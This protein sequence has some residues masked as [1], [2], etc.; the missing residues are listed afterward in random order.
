MLALYGFLSIVLSWFFKMPISIVWSTPGGAL[1][2][3]SGALNYGFPAAVGAFLVAA[4]LLVLTG[5]WPWLGKVAAS[6]PKPI[7]SAMLAG[8]IFNFCIAPIQAVTEFPAIVI[9]A[10]VVWILLMRF[11]KIWAAP[12]AMTI[13][14]L[15][16]S[17]SQGVQLDWA[18]W[19]PKFE[20]VT[21][22]FSWAAVISIGIPLYLVTMASQNIPGVAIMKSLGFEVPFAASMVSTGLGSLVSGLF[23]G[24][25][26]N[27]AAITAAL[28]ADEHAH[29]DR[30]KRWLAS[31]LGG[32]GYIAMA[33]VAGLVV[34]LALKMPHS[35]ILTAAG[36]ALIVTI[37]NAL[38][39]ATEDESLRVPAIVTFLTTTSG[40]VI[41]GIG[42][43]F[44]ALIVGV[45]F[46]VVTRRIPKA[47]SRL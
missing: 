2:V 1:L 31:V 46:W 14:L 47:A 22:E 29:P 38:K 28:N 36:L 34:S 10:I 6:V 7:A 40:I 5:S 15:F 11:A 37:S 12:A 32:F 43:A 35:L 45:L 23:G 20:L 25:S 19:F 21:P 3:A 42:A 44:W 26:L 24:F 18:N 41:Y 16:G 13:I 9:P 8:V 17:I 27:L 39:T 30:S 4:A 33:L